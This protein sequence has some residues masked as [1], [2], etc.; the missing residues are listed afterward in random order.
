[1]QKKFEGHIP[2]YLYRVEKSLDESSL[3]PNTEK[4]GEGF[5]ITDGFS[6]SYISDHY[7]NLLHISGD[8]K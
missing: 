4:I 2:K 8:A 3:W 5:A 6:A 1:M 7:F